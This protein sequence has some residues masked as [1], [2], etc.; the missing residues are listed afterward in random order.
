MPFDE[1]YFR[2]RHAA[3]DAAAALI[4][5][6]IATWMRRYLRCLRA[7]L[8]LTPPLMLADYAD[9]YVDTPRR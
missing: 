8:L 7:M 4:T 5:S 1:R 6:F 2:R 9:Y 3:I